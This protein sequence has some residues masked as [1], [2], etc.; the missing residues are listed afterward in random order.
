MLDQRF[1]ADDGGL[2]AR[3]HHVFGELFVVEDHHFLDVAHAALQ[4]LAQSGNL[5]DHDRR[6]GDGFQHAHL[7]AL[8]ALGDLDLALAGEQRNRAHLAQIHADRVV[9]LFQRARRQVQLD[10]FA[11]FQLE[12]LIA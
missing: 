8:N 6:A 9:G 12:V 5:A 1:D 2:D 3:L 4:I 7:A 10:V 11:L